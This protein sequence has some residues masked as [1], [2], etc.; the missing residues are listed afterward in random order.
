MK[1]KEGDDSGMRSVPND[2]AVA[3]EPETLIHGPTGA[4]GP[5]DQRSD[6]TPPGGE[7]ARFDYAAFEQTMDRLSP[8]QGV[9]ARTPPPGPDAIQRRRTIDDQ[10]IPKDDAVYEIRQLGTYKVVT[11]RG[12]IN[13]SFPGRSIAQQLH[14]SALFDLTEVDR[15]TSFGVRAWLEMLDS[16]RLPFAAFVRA[17]PAVVNQITMMR[18]FCGTARLQ[19]LLAPY[20][21][22]R[23]G[24]GFSV[25][26]D[27]V[28]DRAILRSRT[29]PK[30]LCPECR[31]AAE[32]DEDPWVYFDLDDHLLESVDDELQQVLVHLSDG[33]RRPPVEKSILGEVTR[34]RLNGTVTGGT[35]L[36]RPFGGLEGKCVLD[37]RTVTEVD[38]AGVDNL[39]QRLEKLP[40]EVSRLTLE[41]APLPLVKR[42]LEHRPDRV[43]VNS[44]V[45]T[46]RS[47]S[48]PLRRRMCID[49]KRHRQALRDHQVPDLDLP[50]RDDPMEL[51]GR[52]LIAEALRLLSG[53]FSQGATGSASIASHSAQ[54][55]TPAPAPSVYNTLN[56]MDSF[57]GG[58]GASGFSVPPG[59][60]RGATPSHAPTPMPLAMASHEATPVAVHPAPARPVYAPRRVPWA[61]ILLLAA[62]LFLVVFFT[63][64]LLAL[65]VGGYGINF[66]QVAAGDA[67][68]EATA[69]AVPGQGWSSGGPLPPPWSELQFAESNGTILVV[70]HGTAGDA[71][72]ALSAAREEALDTVLVVLARELRLPFDDEVLP[73]E[74]A[75]RD[76]AL[77]NWRAAS[78]GLKLTRVQDAARR[79]GDGYEIVAQYAASRE[80]LDAL[81]A[82]HTR[83]VGFRGIV[84]APRAPW[85]PPGLRLARRESYIRSV[86]PGDVLRLVGTT[87]V[88][89]LDEFQAVAEAS[90]HALEE[91]DTLPFVFDRDGQS[92]VTSVYKPVTRRAP[93]PTTQN[94]PTLFKKD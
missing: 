39:V 53:D 3:D 6:V 51:E 2:Q 52:D 20:A 58:S 35:R 81:A 31:G 68:V 21:C 12:Q 22:P 28:E 34:V 85:M 40:D 23:C 38:V 33:P 10:S 93:E 29:P 48:R 9:A 77:A 57:S 25:P 43:Y 88:R 56:P 66:G 84:V 67:P 70:G 89:T 73:A 83:E 92:V 60:P 30:V 16:A 19:S 72:L 49:L 71:D 36:Q 62:G 50:W 41:G 24:S 5:R 64:V 46:V 82:E 44:V 26:F 59:P 11:I 63:V 45:T 76:E 94:R 55:G 37:L 42:L 14:G 54:G 80:E 27:A 32:M 69:L 65:Q 47:L 91:G 87:P 8:P 86:E 15:V 61:W 78:A 17:S 74:G 79:T 18:N 75:E 4:G 1:R 13:E 90:Y 7:E